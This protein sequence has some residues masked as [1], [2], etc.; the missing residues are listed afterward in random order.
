[1]YQPESVLENEMLEILKDFKGETDHLIPTRR[2]C[3]EIINKKKR[4]RTCR[5][6]DFA[7]VKIK[8]S[9]KREKH[10][11]FAREQ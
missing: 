8:E 6:V 11:E 2:Q 1:M 10:L 9:E 7:W 3:I 4:E 5:I